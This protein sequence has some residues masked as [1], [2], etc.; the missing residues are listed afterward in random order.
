MISNRSLPCDVLLPHVTYQDLT[1]AIPWL[2]AAFGF[3]EHYRYGD[4]ISGAQLFLGAAIIMVDQEREGRDSPKKLGRGTQCLTIFVDDVNGHFLRA[5]SAGATIVEQPHETVY[6]EYQFAARDLDGHLWLFS[7]HARNLSPVDWGA[8]ISRAPDP[9][10]R[11]SSL[12]RPRFCYFEIPALDPHVSAGFFEKVF[13]WNIRHRDSAHPS[14]DD[15]SGDISGS[16]VSGRE[17]A[18]TPG[19]LPYIWVD[20]IEAALKLVAAHGGKVVEPPHPDSPGSS[21]LIALFTDPAGNLLGLQQQ[22]RD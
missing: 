22:G 12:P 10:A 7:R 21:S 19:L 18:R 13:G 16:F 2:A 15:A 6:G 20:S 14:F 5:K 11:L 3:A 4:P 17:I 1:H 8:V 9:W